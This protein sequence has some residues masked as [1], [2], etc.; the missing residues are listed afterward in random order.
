MQNIPCRD[1]APDETGQ[2]VE[3]AELWARLDQAQRD[4]F[5]VWARWAC[6]DGRHETDPMKT[7]PLLM[8]LDIKLES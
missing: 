6:E 1:Q 7:H 2:I 8:A 3:A 5:E 4:A